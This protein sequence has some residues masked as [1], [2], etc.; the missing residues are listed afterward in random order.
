MVNGSP[1]PLEAGWKHPSRS[2]LTVM[3]T[4]KDINTLLFSVHKMIFTATG[5]ELFYVVVLVWTCLS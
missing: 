4:Q 5:H 1:V 3:T 2:H